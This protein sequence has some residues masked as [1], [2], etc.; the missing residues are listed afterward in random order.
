MPLSS[1]RRN[2][3]LSHGLLE[4]PEPIPPH[5]SK[6]CVALWCAYVGAT[7]KG[8]QTNPALPRG[9]TVD[10]VLEDALFAAGL[11]QPLNYRSR[12]L[13]R[14]GWT[15][16]SRTDRGVSSL[17]TVVTARLEVDAAWFSP[18]AGAEALL[19]RVNA[20]LPPAVRLL[21]AQPVPRSLDARKAACSR[22]YHYLLPCAA[23]G[24]T[25][26]EAAAVLGRL[27]A[28]LHLFEGT[29][30]FHC[31]TK[32]ALYRP[33]PAFAGAPAAGARVDD[34]GPEA[35]G[36]EEEEEGGGGDDSGAAAAGVA[37]P[38]PPAASVG[39]VVGDPAGGSYW[40]LASREEDRIGTAHFRRVHSA[41]AG[42]P[43]GA[44]AAPRGDRD[45]AAA[46]PFVRVEFT[47]ESFVLHQIRK[48]VA[49]AVAV[50]RGAL[51]PGF[52]EASLLRPAR[53]RTPLAPPATLVLADCAFF[54]L[55]PD[56]SV[57]PGPDGAPPPG[58]LLDITAA[59]R[60]RRDAFATGP[61]LAEL[62]P[63]LGDAPA[64]A[65][66]VARLGD[67]APADWPSIEGAAAAYRGVLASRPQ[68]DG[69]RE[70]RERALHD[71]G[72]GAAE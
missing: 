32:R 19:G 27:R 62:A 20:A 68:R 58:R 53:L 24:D 9:S 38:L 43:E 60:A 44:V 36:E 26:A 47:G 59:G 35:A 28:A 64:W 40:C 65:E 15:R 46:T 57:G 6:R 1:E 51:P 49:T 48:M 8:N 55:R 70:A 4:P 12:G 54:P 50:A 61:L 66:W 52:I 63:A 13:A 14:L 23:L 37:L 42:D 30:P 17:A 72:S 16:S 67:G 2:E 21:D 25:P 71:A 18:G 34:D 69:R 29:H 10:D 11:V 5:Y 7:F 33:P 3:L 56:T 22:T 45:G 39:A 31:Y 41:T